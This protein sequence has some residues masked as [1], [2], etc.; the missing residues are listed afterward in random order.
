MTAHRDPLGTLEA[1]VR[2]T[3]SCWKRPAG[4]TARPAV[5]VASSDK[6]YGASEALPYAEDHPLAGRGIYDVI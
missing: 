2:G 1:N 6:A 4:V 3:Y 5:V